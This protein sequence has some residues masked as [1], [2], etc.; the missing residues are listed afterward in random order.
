MA[1]PHHAISAFQVACEARRI[2]QGRG[3]NGRRKLRLQRA[4]ARRVAAQRDGERFTVYYMNCLQPI[5]KK[6]DYF[7]NINGTQFIDEKK[8]IKNKY[9]KD[10]IYN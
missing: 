1:L 4:S 6:V 9:L 3:W 7:I 8:V 5:S 2:E 10:N